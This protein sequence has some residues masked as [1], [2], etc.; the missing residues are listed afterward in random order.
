MKAKDSETISKTK[1]RILEVSEKLFAEKG[2]DKTGVSE[3]AENTGIAK[4]VIY[5]HFKNK[6]DILNVLVKNLSSELIGLKHSIVEKRPE[7]LED[8]A[9]A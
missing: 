2:F 4:S 1:I 7:Q 6:N 3:I 9:K 8:T 5:H